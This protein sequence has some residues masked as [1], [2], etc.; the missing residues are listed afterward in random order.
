MS[1]FYARRIVKRADE[2]AYYEFM[3]WKGGLEG[4]LGEKSR[5]EVNF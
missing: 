3:E 2:E 5:I 1:S 4:K